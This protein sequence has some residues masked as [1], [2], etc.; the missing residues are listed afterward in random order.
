MLVFKSE[1]HILF[2]R[3]DQCSTIV[4]VWQKLQCTAMGILS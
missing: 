3:T 1:N 4:P 2:I